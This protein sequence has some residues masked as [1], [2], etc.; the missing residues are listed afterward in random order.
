MKG[1]Y[2]DRSGAVYRE[3]LPIP[4]PEEGES[5]IKIHY[6]A[7]C[8]TDKEVRKVYRHS[9]RFIMGQEFFGEVL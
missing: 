9:L 2:Y 7:V 3:D 6:S 4:V 1:L 5:L 8:N